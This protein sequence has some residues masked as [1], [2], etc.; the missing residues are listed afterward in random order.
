MTWY[1]DH[2]FF[3][4]SER[5]LFLPR[6]QRYSRMTGALRFSRPRFFRFTKN[7]YYQLKGDLRHSVTEQWTPYKQHLLYFALLQSWY[8]IPI[9]DIWP[10]HKIDSGN[11]WLC[12][13]TWFLK[14]AYIDS[15][16]VRDIAEMNENESYWHRWIFSYVFPKWKATRKTTELKKSKVNATG[17]FWLFT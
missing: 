6:R 7:C 2:N 13:T 14:W 15:A 17:M 5:A 16:R 10:K 1:S 9:Q 4:H 3:L 8:S 12:N 11:R